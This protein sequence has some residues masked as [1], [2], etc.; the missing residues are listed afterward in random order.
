MVPGLAGFPWNGSI[1]RASMAI[2]TFAMR[3]VSFLISNLPSQWF[4]GITS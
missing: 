3:V 4:H 2:A 1:D